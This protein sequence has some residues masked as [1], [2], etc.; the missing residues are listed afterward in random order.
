M[1][2]EELFSTITFD[3][4]ALMPAVSESTVIPGNLNLDAA[5]RA[6]R[7]EAL[8]HPFQAAVSRRLDLRQAAA[9]RTF[10]VG[11]HSYTPVYKGQARPWDAGV[12]YAGAT[13]FAGRLMDALRQEADLL[14]G[15]NEPYRID[16][17]DYT[18]PV[19]GDARGL[20]ALLI[21]VRQDLIGS[22]QGVAEWAERLERCLR[23]AMDPA[24]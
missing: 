13:E 7:L 14:I 16:H 22:A 23:L 10:V 19:H 24:A 1:T 11:I 17:D 3:N 21:E 9:R 2:V 18:V 4:P 6:E 5:A 12:L 20:P 15:E 8:F